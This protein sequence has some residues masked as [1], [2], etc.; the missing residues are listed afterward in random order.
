MELTHLKY[1][2]EVAR[3]QSFTKASKSLRVSQPSIS[4]T[5]KQMEGL[6]GAKLLDRARRGGVTLTDTGRILFRSCESIFQELENMKTRVQLQGAETAGELLL[7]AS[8][9]LCNHVFPEAFEAFCAKHPKVSVR[10]FNG[11][12]ASIKEELLNGRLELGVF[13][14]ATTDAG[15]VAEKLGFVEFVIVT[16][17]KLTLDTLSAQPF[18]SC[19]VNDYQGAYP[20]L[21]MLHALGV[22]PRE[23]FQTNSQETQKRLAL[24]GLGFAVLPRFMVREE[25]K[26]K[27]LV[28]V[29]TTKTIGS[30]LFLVTRRGKT[31][32][33]PAQTLA[34]ELRNNLLSLLRS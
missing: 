15:L 30:D 32:S 23:S 17:K 34:A 26:Q 3:K 6:V 8:D 29:R 18:V 13:Y 28:E 33:K 2:Y 9:N 27:L 14:T 12:S 7:G 22:R 16:K 21:R 1:F 10:L 24:R 4:K 25:L 11:A 19:R 31:L 20:T 5:I